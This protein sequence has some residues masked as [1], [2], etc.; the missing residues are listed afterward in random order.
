[1]SDKPII[2]LVNPQLGENIGFVAR[3]MSNFDFT[4]LRI[5]NPRDGWPN[6]A[7]ESTA[8][9]AINIIK[10]AK[11]F[12]SFEESVSDLEFLYAASA[13]SRDFNKEYI[14]SKNLKSEIENSNI[15]SSK[16]GILFGA[17]KSGLDNETISYA[18][19]ILYIPTS[20]NSPSINIAI[21]VGVLCYEL[22]DIMQN[23][24]QN[25]ELA[26]QKEILNLFSHLEKMLDK[27]NFYKVPEKREK[28][29]QNIRNI[30]KRIHNLTSSEINTLIGMIKA[31][32]EHGR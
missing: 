22:S 28:M 8:V 10:S 24:Y 7:A 27:T 29:L 31:L 19:K 16:I 23:K 20:A 12:S 25:Q 30:F 5:V 18:N 14:N 2:I 3:T 15:R 13:R 26:P 21:S 1:M 6:K 11:I 17:E 4:E 32:F 9:K